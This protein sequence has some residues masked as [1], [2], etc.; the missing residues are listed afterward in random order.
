MM[1]SEQYVMHDV[2]RWSNGQGSDNRC[3]ISIRRKARANPDAL[4]IA[5]FVICQMSWLVEVQ[6]LIFA[7]EHL[8]GSS[9]A[10]FQSGGG[11]GLI[12][13]LCR[14]SL[15]NSY[16]AHENCASWKALR[17][18]HIPQYYSILICYYYL[19]LLQYIYISRLPLTICLC[20]D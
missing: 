6:M 20:L 10:V 14:V 16:K 13:S 2:K 9:I 8:T 7:C 15:S 18:L 4:I 12:S 11:V 5:L 17:E 3:T 1:L 19:R